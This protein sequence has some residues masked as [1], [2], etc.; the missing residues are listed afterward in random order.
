MQ[1]YLKAVREQKHMSI[2]QLSE[3]SGVAR[4]HIEKIES[5]RVNPSLSI[6][7]QLAKALEVSIFDLFSCDE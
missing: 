5:E 3:K 2:R 7:C 6:M 1:I 4:S